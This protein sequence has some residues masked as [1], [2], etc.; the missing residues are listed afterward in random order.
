[1]FGHCEAV[2]HPGD[3]ITDPSCKPGLGVLA[4]WPPPFGGQ[5]LRHRLTTD[6]QVGQDLLGIVHDSHHPRMPIH[7]LRQEGFDPG[8]CLRHP[9]WDDARN[10]T[11]FGPLAAPHGHD[12]VVDVYYRG[13][14]PAEDGMIVNLT[15]I[16]PYLAA[17]LD[18]YSRKIV[19]WSMAEHMETDLVSDALKMALLQRD[20]PFLRQAC[21]HMQQA[22]EKALKKRQAERWR[23]HPKAKLL[24]RVFDL[25]LLEIPRDPN[26]AEF[27][28]VCLLYDDAQPVA[29]L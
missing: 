26:A 25:I 14:V 29:N 21:L 19:G 7:P 4:L 11:V 22:L 15:E 17:V 20:P 28:R 5:K 8:L 16:K 23:E 13:T 6:E 18:C 1:M 12:Y 3:E 2:G 10:A 27:Q 9:E 24:K